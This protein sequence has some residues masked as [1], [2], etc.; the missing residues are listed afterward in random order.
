MSPAQTTWRAE[1]PLT[2]PS[3]GAL[4]ADATP[5]Q[6][7]AVEEDRRRWTHADAWHR[8][9]RAGRITKRAVW[10]RIQNA[11]AAYRDDMVR[12]L[13]ELDMRGRDAA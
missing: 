9:V 2:L 12:R 6:Y 5:E 8:E 4:L 10:E 1:Q 11:P 13:H 7:A 3:A